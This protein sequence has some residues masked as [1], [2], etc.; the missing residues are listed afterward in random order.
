MYDHSCKQKNMTTS[1][2]I[3]QQEI[4]TSKTCN[5]CTAPLAA[6]K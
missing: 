1:F 6:E 2:K 3:S 4:V 5:N